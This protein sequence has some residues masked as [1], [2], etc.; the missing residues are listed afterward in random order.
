MM[1]R[2]MKKKIFSFFFFLK[3]GHVNHVSPYHFTF[4]HAVLK[5]LFSENKRKQEENEKNQK[6]KKSTHAQTEE[7]LLVVVV[8]L[9]L[10]TV[11]F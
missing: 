9:I 8:F 11:L 5:E 6:Q 3:K 4:F 7:L 1:T 2:L 10:R